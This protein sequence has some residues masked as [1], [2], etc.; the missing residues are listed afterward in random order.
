MSVVLC[1]RR[2][3]FSDGDRERLR[4]YASTLRQERI[5][6]RSYDWLLDASLK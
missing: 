6:I 5:E 2:E 1:G 3:L 4:A